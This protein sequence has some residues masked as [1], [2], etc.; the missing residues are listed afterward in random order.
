[1]RPSIHSKKPAGTGDSALKGG[2]I[3]DWWEIMTSC[4]FP[5]KGGPP[6]AIV[7]AIAPRE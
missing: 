5:R 1:M 4:I 6:V 7:Q 3:P 2:R